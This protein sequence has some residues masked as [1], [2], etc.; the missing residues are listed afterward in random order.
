MDAGILT[1][2]GFDLEVALANFVNFLIIF[3][4]FKIFLFKPIQDLIDKRKA[5]IKS[6]LE[7]AN[8]AE[9]SLTS[10]KEET[11]NLIKEARL[12]A[13]NILVEAQNH[14]N[15]INE[16]AVSEGKST[17]SQMKERAEKDILEEK[18]F[19][20]QGVEKEM[21]HLVSSL[22]EKVVRVESK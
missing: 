12:K 4:L 17:V 22:A 21:T 11:E 9:I 18:E 19:M 5:E 1:K 3:L 10:A 20:R 16:K 13:N 6:G 15:E 14:A 7:K 8:Q 2:I